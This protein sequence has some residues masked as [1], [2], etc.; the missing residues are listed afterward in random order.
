MKELKKKENAL[1]TKMLKTEPNRIK[2][3]ITE[4]DLG[5]FIISAKKIKVIPDGRLSTYK[6]NDALAVTRKLWNKC[7]TETNKN[8]DITYEELR[9]KFVTKSKM[10]SKELKNLSWTFRIP[11][12]I[13]EAV[14]RKFSANYETAKKNFKNITQYYYKVRT[15]RGKKIKK[16][17]KKKITMQTRHSKDEKQILYLNKEVCRFEVCSIT[18]KTI[19]S[20]SN[21]IRLYLQEDYKDFNYDTQCKNCGYVA[22]SASV[23]KKH[24]DNKKPCSK[25]EPLPNSG[26]PHAEMIL[27]RI[28]Y[29]YYVFVP[30]YKEQKIKSEAAN[31]IVAIDPGW[32]TL[33]TYYSPHG[34]WGEICPGIKEKINVI[35]DK[36]EKIK[37]SNKKQK[38]KC[39]AIKKRNDHISN[40][41]DDIQWKTCHWLLSKFKKIII[42]RLYVARTNKEGKKIQAD[43]KLCRFVDRLIHKS[44]EYK[45]SEIHIC[46]E[47]HTSQVCTKCL[48]LNTIKDKTVR[49]KD[50]L[51]E[52][53]RD[54]NGARNIFLKHC[55]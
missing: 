1:H 50:C 9:S 40:M 25:I 53:H 55:Y 30:E 28:G 4:E 15:K 6:L 19:L 48:S 13:R 47:H 14:I 8:K 21:G 20:T 41:V 54:L 42:S 16:K 23:L 52:I 32:N 2:K 33:F 31:D 43:L 34:E 11:Q 10:K 49:C 38:S 27:Q 51:H 44:I 36:I 22:P 26:L 5:K 24:L 35:R 37:I 18:N 7:V 3:E 46:K 12:K 17:C 39:K 45:N 29:E